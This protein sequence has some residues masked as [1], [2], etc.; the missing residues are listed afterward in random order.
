MAKVT[1]RLQLVDTPTDEESRRKLYQK[2]HT[3]MKGHGYPLEGIKGPHAEYVNPNEA[4]SLTVKQV[5]TNIQTWV[6]T[7]H[8]KGSKGLVTKGDF[9]DW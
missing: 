8:T 2:L 9:F 7:I 5:A 1:V 3:L 4:D 6:A